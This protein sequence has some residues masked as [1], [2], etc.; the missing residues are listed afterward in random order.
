[1]TNFNEYNYDLPTI[2]DE[3]ANNLKHEKENTPR[4]NGSPSQI[5]AA[6]RQAMA[7]N[8][9]EAIT[10]TPKRVYEAVVTELELIHGNKCA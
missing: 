5:S 1:M 3:F 9:S 2:T 8:S 4:L 10:A 6:I 7:K